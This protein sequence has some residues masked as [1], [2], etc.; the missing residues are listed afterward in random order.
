MRILL[1]T[2]DLPYPSESGAAIRNMGVIRGLAAAGHRLS[3][4]SFAETAPDRESN[5]L[6]E[7]CEE[8]HIVA[9]PRHGKLKRIVK[10]LGSGQADIAFRLASPEYRR[11]LGRLLRENAYDLI[12]FSGIEL[13]CY[14]SLIE[15]SNT[16]AKIVYDAL[17]AE[18]ELQRVVAQVDQG[19][20][21]RL[22]AAMYSTI[23]SARLQQYER[24]ICRAVDAVIA[25]SEQDRG[26]LLKHGGA[27]VRVIP[28][29][30]QVAEYKPAAEAA[31]APRQLV[32]S[33]K[34]DYRPNVDAVEWFHSAVYPLVRECN[35]QAGLLIV[36]RNPHRRLKRLAEHESVRITGWVESVLPFLHEAA[37]YIAPLRMGSG[38]RLKILE[39]MAAGCAV[40]STSIGAAG[41][42]DEVKGALCI[43]DDA[44]AFARAIVSLFDDEKRRRELGAL[45]R[46][47]VSMH[48]DWSTLIPRLL[49]VYEELGL[50]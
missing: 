20:T 4:L 36:G 24:E 40:V 27:P 8:A 16:S 12:Q 48:Y 9:T 26:F 37:V 28:N 1:L 31:R 33:G 22:P 43:A 32:F 49:R 5:P 10:L 23:Q 6:F 17:N 44:A 3:L 7:L 19:L 34:M 38:T 15:A 21:R 2:P 29:G 18:A 45:A 42:N 30:I 41:L 50:G 39:A 14:L 11:M 13:G 35:P 47:R 25:V 46:A